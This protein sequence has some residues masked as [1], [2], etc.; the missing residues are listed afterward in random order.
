MDVDRQAS[1]VYDTPDKWDAAS[2]NTTG[3]LGA[4]AGPG[5][6]AL[7][8]VPQGVGEGEEVESRLP[9]QVKKV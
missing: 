7:Q 5:A 6:V 9:R 4:G 2:F 1:V 8:G 3:A